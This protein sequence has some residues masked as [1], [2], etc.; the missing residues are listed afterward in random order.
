MTP[1]SGFDRK[2]VF[3]DTGGYVASVLPQDGVHTVALV[4]ASTLAKEGWRAFTTNW[5]L[6]EM[7]ALLLS[8]AGRDTALRVLQKIDRSDAD[9]IRVSPA[10][11]SRA[12]EIITKYRDKDFS[13]TDATSFAVMDRLGI[14]HAFTFDRHFLHYGVSPVT[15]R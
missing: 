11:E 8:R 4:I 13:L 6:A 15:P 7:H 2:W 5:V 9:I 12:R 14:R 3:V 10:D 1:L